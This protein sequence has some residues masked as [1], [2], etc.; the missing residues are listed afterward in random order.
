M[1]TKAVV[2][3][4]ESMY[5]KHLKQFLGLTKYYNHF[6]CIIGN[7]AIRT[8]EKGYPVVLQTKGA[9]FMCCS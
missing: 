3:W 8:V 6:V 4:L 9:R 1:K 5:A 7:I 2:D